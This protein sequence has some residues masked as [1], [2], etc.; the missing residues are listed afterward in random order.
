MALIKTLNG[1][2]PSIPDSCYLAENA[3]VI[4][5]VEMGENCS[6][7]FNTVIR[8]DVNSIRIGNNVNIQD[9]VVVHCTFEKSVTKI[10]N[11][12]SIG[13]NAIIHGCEIHDR[14]LIGMGAIVMDNTVIESEVVVAAGAVVPE[15]SKLERGGVYAG[16]PAK[17]IKELDSRLI[18]GEIERI[19]E[20]YLKYSDWYRS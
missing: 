15:N 13:H 5:D 6:I 14:V 3:T 19:A 17:R 2:S 8:G 4:G 11:K 12:V 7:W 16:V 18:E 20:N 1:I 9:G 10:G